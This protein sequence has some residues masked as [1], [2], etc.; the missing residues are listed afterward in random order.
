MK[1]FLQQNG[2]RADVIDIQGGNF[3]SPIWK[4]YLSNLASYAWLAG[5]ALNFAGDKIFNVL[6][7]KT[8]PQFYT[9][10]KQNPMA[11]LGGLFLMNSMATSALATGAFELY[12]DGKLIYSKLETGTVPSSEIVLQ[13]MQLNKIKVA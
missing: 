13:L 3:P 8:H 1:G 7:I 5:L 2:Y 12:L 6:G 9:Y 11:C 4:T 10:M